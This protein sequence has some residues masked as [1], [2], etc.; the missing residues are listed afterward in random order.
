[1]DEL[2]HAPFPL[3][4]RPTLLLADRSFS[5]LEAKTA[6]CYLM[7][8][9]RD[10]VA[11]LDG[12]HAGARARDVIGFG[13]DVPVVATV[14]DALALQPE[15]AVVGT[16]PRGGGLDATMR[17]Q[18]AEC[19]GAGV[20][21]VSGLHVYLDDDPE[22]HALAVAGGARIWD[23]RRVPEITL[24]STGSG[25][26]TGA[27]TVLLVGSDCN[28]GKMTATVEL[29]EAARRRGWRAEWAA[30]G[31]T[32]IM[33]RGRGIAVDRVIADFVGGAAE[34][35]VNAEG[36]DAEVVFVEGQGSINHPGYAGVT[37]GLML[38]AAPDAMVLA[39]AAGRATLKRLD[40][41]IP[42]LRELV[43]LYERLAR[44]QKPAR[45]AA[46]VIN[47]SG[48]DDAAARRVLSEAERETGLPAT[49][50]VRWGCDP[51][52]DALAPLVGRRG[53]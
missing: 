43:A 23:A 53:P 24:V 15:V 34:I 47:T 28:V 42:P 20:D 29:Y 40:V 19:L 2:A 51:V 45:V 8:R 33:L 52:L 3:T 49:D 16:A 38:G 13:G 14:H 35:L 32:G 25:C 41:P 9:A 48:L 5:T 7:Y 22:L 26:T 37:L 12:A 46:L 39:H 4:G 11:V 10:V 30:T 6:A 21:V 50:P 36:R 44:T 18:I 31:Q 27:R 1:M 17:A